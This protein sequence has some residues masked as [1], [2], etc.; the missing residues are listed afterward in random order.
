MVRG[1][2]LEQLSFGK[3]WI[4]GTKLESGLMITKWKIFG[5]QLGFQHYFRSGVLKHA[6][7]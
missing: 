4:K 2:P 6:S 3:I 5:K 7:G 1:Y